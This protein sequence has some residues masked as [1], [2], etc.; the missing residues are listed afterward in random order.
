M[1]WLKK[2]AGKVKHAHSDRRHSHR[3]SSANSNDPHVQTGRFENADSPACC[4]LGGR[5][6]GTFGDD[7]A[8]WKLKSAWKS[9]SDY[10]RHFDADSE[11]AG[12]G[13]DL[14]DATGAGAQTHLPQNTDESDRLLLAY[15]HLFNNRYAPLEYAVGSVDMCAIQPGPSI[16]PT[17]PVG[18]GVVSPAS[19][20]SPLDSS[21]AGHPHAAVTGICCLAR[22]MVGRFEHS[23]HRNEQSTSNIAE[24]LLAHIEIL[25]RYP[26][27][28]EALIKHEVPPALVDMLKIATPVLHTG[29]TEDTHTQMHAWR[30]I[31]SILIT[32]QRCSDPDGQWARYVRNPT[33]LDTGAFQGSSP[34]RLRPQIMLSHSI[35]RAAVYSVNGLLI[36]LYAHLQ[37]S[38]SAVRIQCI[39]TLACLCSRHSSTV[40]SIY[41][42]LRKSGELCSLQLN[43]PSLAE[44][45]FASEGAEAKWA[46]LAGILKADVLT[47]NYVDYASRQNLVP[48]HLLVNEFWENGTM[49]L[50]MWTAA[51]YNGETALEAESPLFADMHLLGGGQGERSALEALCSPATKLVVSAIVTLALIQYHRGPQFAPASPFP[52]SP[53]LYSPRIHSPSGSDYFASQGAEATSWRSLLEQFEN[54]L[55]NSGVSGAEKVPQLA[56]AQNGASS[57]LQFAVIYT[58]HSLLDEESFGERARE[59]RRKDILGV[60][61]D[62]RLWNHFSQKAFFGGIP[63]EGLYEPQKSNAARSLQNAILEFLRFSA[64]LTEW[65]NDGPCQAL[66]TLL[67][68]TA[69]TDDVAFAQT[70]DTL[71]RTLH[72]RCEATQEA[73]IRLRIF[74]TLIPLISNLRAQGKHS[75]LSSI[76]TLLRSVLDG[77]SAIT[78]DVFTNPAAM[79]LLFDMLA[80]E[81]VAVS[82][83]AQTVILNMPPILIREYPTY[84]QRTLSIVSDLQLASLGGDQETT[85]DL[86]KRY[87]ER[88]PS[89]ITRAEE[90]EYQLRLL[91]GVRKLVQNNPECASA[92]KKSLVKA[93]AH[94]VLLSVLS[95]KIDLGDAAKETQEKLIHALAESVVR[96]LVVIM[97]NDHS[98]KKTFRLLRGYDELLT[99]I[100]IKPKAFAWSELISELFILVADGDTSWPPRLHNGDAVNLLFRTYEYCSPELRRRFVTKLKEVSRAHGANT[101]LLHNTGA[102]S[103]ILKLVLPLVTDAGD[104]DDIMSLLKGIA[105]YSL[106]VAEVKLLLQCLRRR[107]LANMPPTGKTAP[108]WA[109]SFAGYKPMTSQIESAA[110]HENAINTAELPF[111]YDALLR[112]VLDISR[113]QDG[114]L[115]FYAF[116]GSR[117]MRMPGVKKW[118]SGA[119]GWSFIAWVKFDAFDDG[120]RTASSDPSIFC[121]QSA[122]AE[123]RLEIFVKDGALCVAVTRQGKTHVVSTLEAA[124]TPGNWHCIVVCQSFP[125]MPW[126]THAE[127]AIYVDGA[128]IWKGK[129]E[130]PETGAYIT[131]SLGCSAGDE[132]SA[133]SSTTGRTS[134]RVERAL[135][136][137]M[138]SVYLLDDVLLPQQTSAI[139]LLGP[140]FASSLTRQRSGRIP[141]EPSP[142]LDMGKII[143]EFHP[144]ATKTIPLQDES[145]AIVA[146]PS[147]HHERVSDS[148]IG[149]DQVGRPAGGVITC[150]TKCFQTGIH[151]LGG[152]GILIPILAQVDLHG[153]ADVYTEEANDDLNAAELRRRN[154]RKRRTSSFFDL[155]SS[156]MTRDAVHRDTFFAIKGPKIVASLL[157]QND[158]A[159]LGSDVFEALIRFVEVCAQRF[160]FMC[161]ELI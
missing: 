27:D 18:F 103:Q 87:F 80:Q 23:V 7:D 20:R 108:I 52:N 4:A 31:Q 51:I 67:T 116:D 40:A 146:Y 91:L 35:I 79:S 82:S 133:R 36:A 154:I 57:A 46:S 130:F 1:D 97:R 86:L 5:L 144:L 78:I 44:Y 142:V 17:S 64:T 65:P 134:L 30:C 73:L 139:Y 114:D 22:R 115:D 3:P 127:A 50:L 15:L 28:R 61:E 120:G 119:T 132:Q 10:W 155:M 63:K 140:A 16:P 110:D 66:L 32:L 42:E 95:V 135:T 159:N 37:P 151:A 100:C 14:H 56:G 131:A 160:S 12:G 106:T 124:L 33:Q 101:A 150:R 24:A 126:S 152:V 143:L 55:R 38:N 113:E 49:S 25:S 62:L 8:A 81:T 29:N 19:V 148:D 111:W 75:L 43:F 83:F 2:T 145:G 107:D 157:Q 98:A 34:M 123:Q 48:R 93:K 117:G 26:G 69:A 84:Q 54:L 41:E 128:A 94:Q 77:S 74:D 149:V 109:S 53:K 85:S 158:P 122:S 138:T 136:G 137:Q 60:M 88:F 70:C 90:A 11:A 105:S 92:L 21:L 161:F 125:K 112:M 118:P 96:T 59:L 76:I 13:D 102:F 72:D 58:L 156:V 89:V 45:P 6:D 141:D 99:R 121:L 129:Q 104:L 9:V 47:L 153:G 39:N 68:D 147:S 71:C